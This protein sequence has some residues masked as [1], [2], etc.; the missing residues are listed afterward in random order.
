VEKSGSEFLASSVISKQC[1][2]KT[3]AHN[4]VTLIVNGVKRCSDMAFGEQS[5]DERHRQTQ[6]CQMVCFQTK[7]PKFG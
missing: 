4:P 3:I 5:F 2:K 6:G 7:N 1:P